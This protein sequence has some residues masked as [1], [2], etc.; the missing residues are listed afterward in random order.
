MPSKKKPVPKAKVKETAQP[1]N[2]KKN[3]KKGKK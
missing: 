3:K 1:K 2:K